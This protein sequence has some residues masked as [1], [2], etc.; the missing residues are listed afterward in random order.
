MIIEYKKGIGI[1][2]SDQH[3]EW[4]MKRS[5]V[6][7]ILGLK[8]KEENHDF[9]D[10]LPD[11]SFDLKMERDIYIE[12]GNYHFFLNY[13]DDLLR[14]IEVHENDIIRINGVEIMIGEEIRDS[15]LK[16]NS[17]SQNIKQTEKGE[18]LIEDLK[19]A[20]ADSFFMGG[21]S[22]ML[23]YFYASASISHLIDNQ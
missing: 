18:Y 10:L 22:T 17:I 2:I 16:I 1:I 14:S 19:I 3:V 12:K 5:E 20:L 23:D 21:D 11:D 13:K 8:Y 4:N 9:S 7:N 6:R 15:L